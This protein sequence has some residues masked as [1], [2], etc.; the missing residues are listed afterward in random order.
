MCAW[1]VKDLI[2]YHFGHLMFC[3]Y[4]LAL[5]NLLFVEKN[6]QFLE[7]T[8]LF[9]VQYGFPFIIWQSNDCFKT[10]FRLKFEILPK[11]D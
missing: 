1:S 5:L 3:F 2:T 6:N 9:L 4:F 8:V 7:K 10:S 11:L